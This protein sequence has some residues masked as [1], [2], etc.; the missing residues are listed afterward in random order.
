MH[1]SDLLQDGEIDLFECIVLVNG[2]VVLDLLKVW[3]GELTCRCFSDDKWIEGC[4]GG[5]RVVVGFIMDFYW[6]TRG[7]SW[8][9]LVWVKRGTSRTRSDG[10]RGSEQQDCFKHFLD[11]EYDYTLSYLYSSVWLCIAVISSV[12]LT[13]IDWIEINCRK[14]NWSTWGHC[15]GSIWTTKASLILHSASR[16]ASTTPTRSTQIKTERSSPAHLTLHTHSFSQFMPRNSTNTRCTRICI[17]CLHTSQ[18]TQLLIPLLHNQPLSNNTQTHLFPLCNQI[19]IRI[20]LLQTIIVQL[21][22]YRFAF[23]IQF[24]DI[25]GSLMM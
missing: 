18:T 22:R 6:C 21:F 23:M 8:E 5:C 13:W 16:R 11:A 19:R 1:S 15:I 17:L 20:S 3:K 4:T 25:S 24:K 9:D 14:K 2:H 10:E 7:L 12:H